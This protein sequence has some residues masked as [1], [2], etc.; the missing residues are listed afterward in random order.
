MRNRLS[1]A[2]RRFRR[3]GL[4]GSGWTSRFVALNSASITVSDYATI[5][6]QTETSLRFLRPITDG[7]GFENSAPGA[8]VSFTSTTTRLRIT[9]LW[10][11]LVTR[12][13]STSSISAYYSVGSVLV[14]GTEVGTFNSQNA[15][16]VTATQQYEFALGSGSK[17]VSIVFP[18]WTGMTLTGIEID[19]TATLA[20]ASRPSSKLAVCGDSITQG[21]LSTS[22]GTI[23]PLQ[24]AALE[25]LQLV[26]FANGGA[27]A[28]AAD[29]TT[30]L[31]S[32]GASGT[33]KVTYMI[34]YNNFVAQTSLVTFQTAV[35][36]WITNARAALPSAAIHIISPIYS[37]NTNTITLAQYRSAVQAAELATG[38]ANTF[39]IDGLS[40]MTNNTNRL[41]D[42]IHPNNTGAAEIAANLA[43]LI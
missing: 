28:V 7:N 9:V 31:T 29:A 38:D 35:Q 15:Y 33:T 34:G 36:G 40:I 39:Y 21:A 42:N 18:Y 26:N 32:G 25:S 24:L 6:A 11:A 5:A 20:T 13:D 10:N 14:N 12:N 3:P 16:N 30:A 27:L 17:T 8:R 22:G 43:G 4:S 37:P 41:T 1:N 23:W 2:I 19:Q